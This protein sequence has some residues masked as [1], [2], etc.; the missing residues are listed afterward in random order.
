MVGVERSVGG[1][2]QVG[3]GE[4][5]DE[6]VGDVDSQVTP[7]HSTPLHLQGGGLLLAT[8]PRPLTRR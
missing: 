6:V 8:A 4:R 1:D 7:L 5:R 3:D 2:E